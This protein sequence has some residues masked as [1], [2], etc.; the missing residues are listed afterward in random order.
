M[1]LNIHAEDPD[2]T[3]RSAALAAIESLANENG[4]C[5]PWTKIN[6][7]FRFGSERVK[8]ANRAK[9][10]F[11]PRQMSGALSVKTVV[12]RGSRQIWYQ[13]QTMGGLGFDESTGLLPYDLAQGGRNDWTNQALLQARIRDAPLIYFQGIEAGV[14]V[15]IFPVWISVFDWERGRILLSAERFD[16]PHITERIEIDRY[17]SQSSVKT[18]NHQAWFSQRVRAA[19]DWRCAVTGLPVRELLVGAHIIPDSE[20]GRASINNGICM[21]QLH[22]AAYDSNLLGIDTRHQI[23]V[24]KRIGLLRDGPFL[25]DFKRLEGRTIRLPNDKMDWPR[26]EWLDMR[27]EKYSELER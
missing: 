15:P 24:S 18:R 25:E 1:N 23:H 5:L 16:T 2:R 3:I 12:P 17:Y 26:P 6:E 4:Y 8:F 10:I 7:G 22:H 21:S 19:Y 14:Y 13:D 20:G 9:G 11:K 27:F